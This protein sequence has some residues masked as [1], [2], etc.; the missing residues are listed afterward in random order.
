MTASYEVLAERMDKHDEFLRL[1]SDFRTKHHFLPPLYENDP[2]VKLNLEAYEKLGSWRNQPSVVA[3][4]QK[5]AKKAEK[6]K[7]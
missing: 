3:K 2:I 4:I 6:N 1:L 5:A 7:H